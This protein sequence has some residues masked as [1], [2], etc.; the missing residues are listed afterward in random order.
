MKILDPSLINIPNN[1]ETQMIERQRLRKLGLF[2]QSDEIR[3]RLSQDYIIYDTN[4][5]DSYLMIIVKF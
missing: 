1:V 2:K 3:T 5:D 4:S